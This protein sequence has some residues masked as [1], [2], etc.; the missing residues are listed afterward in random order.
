MR[1]PFKGDY[2]LSQKFG[3]KLVLNGKD[4]YAQFGLKG[5]N[6]LDYAVPTGTE[7]LAAHSGRVIKAS[8]DPKGYGNY[9]RIENDKE[10]SLVAHLQSFKVKEGDIVSE[11]QVIGI[12]DNTGNSTAPHLHF[13][14]YLIPRDTSNGYGGYSDPLPFIKSSGNSGQLEELKQC[15]LDRD[16]N[17]NIAN[18]IASSVG[19]SID[20]NDKEGSSDSV[21]R[22]INAYRGNA[23]KAEELEKQLNSINTVWES[24][25]KDISDQNARALSMKED[26]IS[27]LNGVINGYELSKEQYMST[28]QSL[29]KQL[30]DSKIQISQLKSGIVRPSIIEWLIKLFKK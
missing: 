4:I 16:Q 9:I 30:L 14:Y 19:M 5:H 24:K 6:G 18:K 10:G 8:S 28:V 1:N 23:A 11:G 2:R 15:N 22:S 26:E 27:R 12:S 13:G 20:A 29:E 17:W 3:N 25:L 7:I 21:I